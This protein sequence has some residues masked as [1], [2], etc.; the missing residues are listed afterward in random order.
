M[1]LIGR[2]ACFQ[3]AEKAENLLGTDRYQVTMRGRVMY[4]C[5]WFLDLLANYL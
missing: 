1:E 4:N 5:T 3:M 2:D